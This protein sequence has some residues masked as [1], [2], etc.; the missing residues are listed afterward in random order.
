MS[1]TKKDD[2]G[3]GELQTRADE[4]NAKGYIGTVPDTTPNEAYTLRG[5]QSTTTKTLK[6]DPTDG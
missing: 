6:K 4:V 3:L 2:L 5:G 1:I